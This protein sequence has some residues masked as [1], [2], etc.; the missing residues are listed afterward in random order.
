MDDSEVNALTLR[1]T[2]E[3]LPIVA[4]GASAGGL[5]SFEKF[6]RAASSDL[7]MGYVLVS[8]MDPNSAS[9]LVELLSRYTP[10]PVCTAEHGMQVQA[11]HVYICPPDH[12]IEIR[13]GKLMLTEPENRIGRRTIID[14]FMRA[15]AEDQKENAVGIILSGTGDDGAL[16]LAAIKNA[17]G[18]TFA[19]SPDTALKQEMPLAAIR[20][21]TVDWILPAG[22]MPAR[23][24]GYASTVRRLGQGE[25]TADQAQFGEYLAAILS[26]LHAR[27]RHDFRAY[28]TGTITRRISRRMGL[29]HIDQISAYVAYLRNKPS[30]VN[31]LFDDF[32]IGATRFFREPEAFATLAVD[33]I[34]SL[35]REKFQDEPL[36]VWVAGCATGEEAY[37]IAMLLTECLQTAEQHRVLQIFATDI[38]ESALGFARTGLYPHGIASDITPERLQ[39]WFVKEEHGYRVVKQIRESVVFATQNL[40]SDPPFSKLDLISCRNLLIYL[41]PEAQARVMAL[42]EFALVAGGHLFLGNSETVAKGADLFTPIS[43]KWRIYR[44]SDAGGRRLAQIPTLQRADRSRGGEQTPG[45][46]GPVQSQPAPS[47]SLAE[48][49]QSQIL[50]E[51]APACVVI[52]KSYKVRHFVG[53]TADYIE[54]P[55]GAPTQDLRNMLRKG[56]RP[57]L[58]GAI[59]RVLAGAATAK[60]SA[61]IIRGARQ[62]AVR[63]TVQPLQPEHGSEKLLLVAFFD[64][65]GPSSAINVA[66]SSEETLLSQIERELKSTREELQGMIEELEAANEELKTANEEGL[67]MNE[68]LQSSNEE[69]EASREELQ[70]LNEELSTVNTEVQLKYSEAEIAN[71]DLSNL[72][73]CSDM[74]TLFLDPTCRIR[75][76]TPAAVGLFSLLNTDIGRPLGDIAH[77]FAEQDLGNVAKKVMRTQ[78]EDEAEVRTLDSRWYI[79]RTL[80][81]LTA[82]KAADGVVIT[83]SDIT[84]LKNT[85]QA[86]QFSEKRLRVLYDDNPSMYFTIDAD[87]MIFSVNRYGAEQLGYSAP[88]LE[89]NSFYALNEMP[90]DQ[91][92]KKLRACLLAPQRAHRWEGQLKARNGTL[93]WAPYRA[94]RIGRGGIA[95]SAD[96]Q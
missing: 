2:S 17:G 88:L 94:Q 70:S 8:H 82:D 61:S 15:L 84:A 95:V 38:D 62:Q 65:A 51:F 40:I 63:A 1:L 6:F 21:R 35:L 24:A 20:M 46:V 92:R 16:G 86:L 56:L 87:G 37:S 78:H 28:K 67:S 30:E 93:L 29:L 31:R 45:T 13:A 76:F 75:R 69:Q 10:M 74:A 26:L 58:R 68:E 54:Q 5:V 25:A 60:T 83:F 91:L 48:L 71:N 18:M 96:C 14:Q 89:G 39:R 32:L 23:L 43:R 41:G 59:S 34:P 4:L 66:E 49:V 44:R 85:E 52:D 53:A 79:R 3:S 11:D 36:R 77:R 64:D 22:E 81:Y 55:T 9:H 90:E 42:F 80:P 19:E 27:T 33:V 12:G 72:L 50:R 73:N 47:A 7:T 57:K